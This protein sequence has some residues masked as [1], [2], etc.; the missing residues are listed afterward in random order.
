MSI[1]SSIF[2]VNRVDALFIRHPWGHENFSFMVVGEVVKKIQPPP[3][4]TPKMKLDSELSLDEI[5]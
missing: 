5:R 4:S 1:I 3:E 2:R